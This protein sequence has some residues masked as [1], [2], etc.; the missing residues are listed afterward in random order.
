MRV[1]H[2]KN[3]KILNFHKMKLFV[4]L[5][6][7]AQVTSLPNVLLKIMTNLKQ[8]LAGAKIHLMIF[9]IQLMVLIILYL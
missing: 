5:Y 1:K 3:V 6:S 4:V 2:D 7:L 9:Y 8:M